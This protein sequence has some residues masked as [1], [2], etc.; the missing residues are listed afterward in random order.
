MFWH[1]IKAA[2]I[3]GRCGDVLDCFIFEIVVMNM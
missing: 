2:N 1:V 3:R